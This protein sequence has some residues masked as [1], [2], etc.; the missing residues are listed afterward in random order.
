MK[1]ALNSNSFYSNKGNS[2][3]LQFI[4]KSDRAILDVGCGAG[5]TGKLI[6]SIYPD[7]EVVGITCSQVEYDQASQNLSSCIYMNVE[8]ETLPDKYQNLF[9]VLVLSHVLEHLINPT[10]VICKLLPYLKP[11]GKIIIAL[12][13]I[14]NWRERVKL[15]LGKFEYT[16]GGVMDKTHL[17]FYTF[18]TATKYLIAP[19]NEL[20]IEEN[21]VN[22]SVPLAFF[23]HYLLS[24]E[25]KQSLDRLGCKYMPN[26]FGGEILIVAKYMPNS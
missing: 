22:G 25:M 4:D 7:I 9:D 13:N 3:I 26:L 6:L 8:Q 15:I 16:D 19:I 10:E 2:S 24:T 14:A 21:F 23:R 5:D 11:N 1:S 17:H 12:P 20:K 18:H